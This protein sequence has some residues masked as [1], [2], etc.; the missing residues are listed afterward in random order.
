MS[1]PEMLFALPVRVEVCRRNRKRLIVVDANGGV[2]LRTLSRSMRDQDVA[3]RFARAM[4]EWS[5]TDGD[6]LQ[7]F[8]FGL[9]AMPIEPDDLASAALSMGS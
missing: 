4:N 2:L 1:A 8:R 9:S 5:V 6:A 7:P 3:E